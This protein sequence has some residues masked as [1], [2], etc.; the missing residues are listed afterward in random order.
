[1]AKKRKST[2]GK[3]L[4]SLIPDV[5]NEDF[6]YSSSKTLE[7]LLEEDV[8]QI[9]EKTENKV[10]KKISTDTEN[11]SEDVKPIAED[12]KNI[13][14]DV[15]L[16]ASDIKH[17]DE[18]DDEN[19][20]ITNVIDYSESKNNAPNEEIK[21]KTKFQELN[22]EEINEI[23][24]IVSKNPRITL[25]S[26]KSAAVFRYLRKTKPEFSIS[27]EA[28]KLIDEAVCVKYPEIWKLFED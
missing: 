25:W 18:T 4:D 27:K 21:E 26:Q 14:A 1:M 23:V 20:E 8:P 10:D 12:I 2:L 19:I 13:T 5:Y 6:D 11:I 28:S 22:Q 7:D 17:S 3:G 9:K 15:E 24:K 16:I